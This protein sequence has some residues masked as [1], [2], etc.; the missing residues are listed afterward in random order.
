M[1]I[2]IIR[3]LISADDLKLI[4][5]KLE[6]IDWADGKDTAHGVIKDVKS[7]QQSINP[8][9]S[10]NFIN[11]LIINAFMR[12]NFVQNVI[13]P[14]HVLYPFLNR[15]KDGDH[16][17]QHIDRP[18]RIVNAKDHVRCDLSM[19]VFL[20][21]DYEG[22][23]LMIYNG[24]SN[25]AVKLKKGDAVL[26]PSGYLHEV[27]KITK[28]VRICAVTWI[29]SGIRDEQKRDIIFDLLKLGNKLAKSDL[30]TQNLV[31]KIRNNLTREWCEF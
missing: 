3:N 17:G 8:C 31:S 23:E 15:Y 25:T 6:K 28:G 1:T 9:E 21:D 24:D 12:H 29:Q 27:K 5:G 7:N 18:V 14:I 4:D 13:M 2:R 19:T 16:Y 22:G 10:K 26:Y 30:E 11:N 20:N